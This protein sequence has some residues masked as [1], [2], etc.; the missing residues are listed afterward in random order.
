MLDALNVDILIFDD[1]EVLDFAGPFEVFNVA[2]HVRGKRP[3]QVYTVAGKPGPVTARGGLSI[4][5][6]YTVENCPPADI[7]V[8]SGGYGTRREMFNDALTGWIAGAAARA[9][10]TASVCTGSILLAKA[11]LP[12]STFAAFRAAL[13]A[14]HE[15]GFVGTVGGAT[16]LRRGVVERV[17]TQ[18]ETAATVAEPLLILLRRFATESAREEARLFCDELMAEDFV[19]ALSAHAAVEAAGAA[20]WDD[21]DAGDDD[22]FDDDRYDDDELIAA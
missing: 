21:G 5:P 15:I 6:A 16:R 13:E 17:L 18:C 9:E 1:V 8:V 3:F 19:G 14:S 7:L 22:R 2:G 11:G 10:L 20:A 12:E 4:N